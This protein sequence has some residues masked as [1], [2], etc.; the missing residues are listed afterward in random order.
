MANNQPF[1]VTVNAVT[2]EADT[3]RSYDLRSPTGDPLPAFSPGAHID[4][5]L[6]IG[7]T[8]SYSLINISGERDRYVIAVDNAP[9]SRGGSRW[10]SERVAVGDALR[11]S[12]PINQFPL[13]ESAPH[14]VLIA[15][16]IGI[17]PLLAMARL[18]EK[19]GRSWELHYCARSAARAAFLSE[20]SRPLKNGR[21]SLYFSQGGSKLDLKLIAQAA[22][23]EAHLY[24]CGPASMLDEFLRAT[25]DRNQSYIHTERFCGAAGATGGNFDLILAKSGHVL[26][27]QA[28]QTILDRLIEEG[29]QVPNSCREGVCGSCE[30][31]L[32]AGRADHRDLIL[33][34]A[35]KAANASIFV[36]CSGSLTQSLILDL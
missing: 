8:R 12:P 26:H 28:G 27:V 34:D 11:I 5:H 25:Q 30:V 6:D 33:T 35:E 24:C 20:L 29:I 10:L 2:R 14:S 21:V 36:C 16:G 31:K 7:A 19:N 23:V 32:L 15:G 1:V 13:D 9:R 22:P 4:V 17:T 18:L 3:I